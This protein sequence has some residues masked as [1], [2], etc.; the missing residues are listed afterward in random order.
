MRLHPP[1]SLAP[2]SGSAPVMV[3]GRAD[4]GFN[5]GLTG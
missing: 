3:P 2:G 4:Q 5:P 1:A